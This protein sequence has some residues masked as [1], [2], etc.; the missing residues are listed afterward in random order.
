MATGTGKTVVMAMVIA[1]QVLNK[2]AYPQDRRFSRTVLVVAPGLTVRSRLAVLDPSHPDNYYRQFRIVPSAL[3]DTLRRG[4]VVIRNWHALNW[5]SA[6]QVARRRSYLREW[7]N[8]VNAHGGF[9]R[10]SCAVSANPGEIHDILAAR[11]P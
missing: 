6:E 7:V 2:A 4:R 5:E 1:W 9:G 8:A 3:L 11:T 10:W